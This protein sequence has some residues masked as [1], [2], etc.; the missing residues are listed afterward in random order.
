MPQTSIDLGQA[1]DVHSATMRA[2][3]DLPKGA[4]RAT[5]LLVRI[6]AGLAIIAI[7]MLRLL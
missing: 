7:V 4:A 1:A 3:D 6:S 2:R 5:S